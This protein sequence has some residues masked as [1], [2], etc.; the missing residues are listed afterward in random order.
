MTSLR[1]KLGADLT[2]IEK[3][4]GKHLAALVKKE[5]QPYLSDGKVLLSENKVYLSNEGKLFA[6]G[7]AASLFIDDELN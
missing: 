1:S 4:F 3:D 6:D 2:K 7:I 5:V